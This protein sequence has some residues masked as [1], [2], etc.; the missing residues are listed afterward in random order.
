M[1]ERL[2]SGKYRKK[3]F[4]T[5][6]NGKRV[7]K[8]FT[9]KTSREADYLAAAFIREHKRISSTASLTVEDAVTR[10]IDSSNVVLS[11]STIRGYNVIKR[12]YINDIKGKRLVDLDQI[13]LQRWINKLALTH[14]P[15]TCKNAWSLVSASLKA[16]YPESSFSINL[17]QKEVH[18]V[19][20]P[21]KEDIELLLRESEGTMLYP[22][23][24]LGSNLGMR[25]SEIAA[26]SWEDID[27][28]R[29]QIHVRHALVPGDYGLELKAPKTSAGYRTLDMTK[30]VYEYFKTA[31]RTKK[32]VQ[33]SPGAMTT[34]FKRLC[35]RLDLPFNQHLLRHYFA[36]VCAAK[37]LP[38]SYA[39][40]L[41]G[42]SSYEMIRKVY[43]HILNEEER[44]ARKK[45]LDYFDE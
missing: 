7:S 8:S 22:V 18:E 33:M 12:N 40:M 20:I 5:D 24:L 14:S 38:E 44:K 16:F 32:P 23:I 42:H 26:L 36:S 31:D 4:Y 30:R 13:A 37:G 34:S 35:K 2:P 41:M 45:I 25:R 43:G 19:I 21:Q 39:A 3:A 10:L 17:P 1:A 15:K 6:E 27:M 11:P 9:A 28:K 29:K